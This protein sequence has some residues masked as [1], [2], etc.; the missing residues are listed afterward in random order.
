MSIIQVCYIW[1]VCKLSEADLV[2]KL[3][4][5]RV[6]MQHI[7]CSYSVGMKC[8]MLS[9]AGQRDLLHHS[10]AVYCVNSASSKF[11]WNTV[12]WTILNTQRRHARVVG[13][14]ARLWGWMAQSM[15]RP[16]ARDLSL[17]QNLQISYGDHAA[18]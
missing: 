4:S 5:S 13:I 17:L 7:F 16:E 12:W 9:K 15:N 1:T 2:A 10:F 18:S 3:L 11:V 6:Q 14:V 8:S